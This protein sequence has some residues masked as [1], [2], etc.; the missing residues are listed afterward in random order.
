MH[1]LLVLVKILVIMFPNQKT[2]LHII[3]LDHTTTLFLDPVTPSNIIDITSKLKAKTR[4]DDISSTLMKES[5]QYIAIPIT[6]VINQSLLTG[7]VPRN[8]KTAKVIPIFK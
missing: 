8:M 6:H 1:S 2:I 4:H 7:T 5:I 3:Y